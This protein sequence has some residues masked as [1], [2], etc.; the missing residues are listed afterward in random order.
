MKG[1]NINRPKRVKRVLSLR[2]KIIRSREKLFD[3]FCYLIF[4]HDKENEEMIRLK[5]KTVTR[6]V[7]ESQRGLPVEQQSVFIMKPLTRAQVAE[8][9]DRL[10]GFSQEGQFE[11]VRT[12]TVAYNIT[13][14]SLV[15]WENILLE[16]EDGQTS[17]MQFNQASKAELYDMLPEDIQTELESAFGQGGMAIKIEKA[18]G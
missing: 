10:M 18:D 5:K 6:Y 13:L 2:T 7:P 11:S 15:G 1:R 17:Q 4:Y 9:R 8:E 16:D 14:A 3:Y 12:S